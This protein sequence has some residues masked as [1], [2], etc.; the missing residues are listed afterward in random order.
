MYIDPHGAHVLVSRTLCS[1][2][3][4]RREKAEETK[5]Y[6]RPP[7][8]VYP[9]L[10]STLEASIRSRF[11]IAESSSFLC[12]ITSPLAS[13]RNKPSNEQH[14]VTLSRSRRFSRGRGTSSREN[15][16]RSR[17]DRK[18]C[19]RKR[20]K[21]EKIASCRPR[22]KPFSVRTASTQLRQPHYATHRAFT[23]SFIYAAAASRAQM[24]TS[25]REMRLPV[26]TYI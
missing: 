6:N 26:F 23:L 5:D 10:P 9:M 17:A 1:G 24:H 2:R 13:R 11:Q 8:I 22:S 4:S 15:S 21:E 14:I 18:C 7:G 20:Q 19:E 16:R 3:F 25:A 12:Q